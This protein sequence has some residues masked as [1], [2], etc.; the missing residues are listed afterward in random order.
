MS[1]YDDDPPSLSSTPGEN[2]KKIAYSCAGGGNPDFSSIYKEERISDRYYWAGCFPASTAITTSFIITYIAVSI[3]FTHYYVANNDVCLRMIQNKFDA[4]KIMND[5]VNGNNNFATDVS[6]PILALPQP[7]SA[8][9]AAAAPWFGGLFGSRRGD[10]GATTSLNNLADNNIIG[11]NSY[12]M[13]RIGADNFCQGKNSI[14]SARDIKSNP[15]SV[16]EISSFCVSRCAPLAEYDAS[17]RPSF[18]PKFMTWGYGV[19]ACE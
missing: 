17:T 14:L 3:L 7:P 4:E 12:T 15:Q 8:A 9:A 10:T 6:S 18:I 5:Y 19:C 2:A 13:C 1:R 16:N 11:G